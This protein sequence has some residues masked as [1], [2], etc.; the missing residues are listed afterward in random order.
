MRPVVVLALVVTAG[1]ALASG[2]RA[3]RVTSSVA[4]TG[5][6]V[7]YADSIGVTALTLTPSVQFDRDFS[8]LGAS[9]SYSQLAAG[10]WTMQGAGTGSLYTSPLRGLTGELS[11]SLGGST[12]GDGTRTGQSI[13]SARAHLMTTGRGAWIGAGAGGT[14]DGDR[15]R[16]LLQGEAA[17]WT[18]IGERTT[19]LAT[20]T[21]VMVDDTSRYT[22]AE[23]AAHWDGSRLEVGAS[24][25][26]RSGR[27]RGALSG[28]GAWGGV[29]VAAWLRSG[30]AVVGSAGV[31]P[32]DL[33]QGYPDGR[34]LSLGVRL[35]QRARRPLAEAVPIVARER[36]VAAVA[37]VERF[38][39]TAAAG[40]RQTIRVLAPNARTVELNGDFTRWTPIR[41][42]KLAGGWWSAILPLASGTYQLNVRTDGG[43]WIVPPGLALLKD[44][45]GGSVGLLVIP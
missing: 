34:Y 14:W 28:A 43:A 8:T 4:F 38:T 22:D 13:A 6:N 7:R 11:A 35:G 33:T 10:G 37:G 29:S 32:A 5:A 20:V 36:D 18:R 45:F 2:A 23:V 44:E 12:H 24:V 16:T 42:T 17:A 19:A 9:V 27:P 41:L 1:A 3:Q 39:T 31:Y 40:G 15:W 25:G 26:A 21:P 30:I